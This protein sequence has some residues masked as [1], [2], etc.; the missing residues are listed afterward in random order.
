MKTVKG[1]KVL[2]PQW[3]AIRRQITPKIGQLTQDSATITRIVRNLLCCRVLLTHP[4]LDQPNLWAHPSTAR[5][6]GTSVPGL[7]FLFGKGNI[8][9]SGDRSDGREEERHSSGARHREPF[10]EIARLRRHLFREA[11]TAVRRMA[12]ALC[13]PVDRRWWYYMG[14]CSTHKSHGIPREQRRTRVNGRVCHTH[15]W[16]DARVF[17]R[18]DCPCCETTR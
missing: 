2:K 10:R 16:D 18:P 11:C 6:L 9:A 15:L 5:F 12:G 13:H 14:G 1:D 4:S 17:P 3:N 8:A 7:T